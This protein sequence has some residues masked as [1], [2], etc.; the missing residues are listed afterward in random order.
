[1]RQTSVHLGMVMYDESNV[2]GQ[3]F[4]RGKQRPQFGQGLHASGGREVT[5]DET[6]GGV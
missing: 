6:K 2:C 1:M 4:L 5:I 3:P